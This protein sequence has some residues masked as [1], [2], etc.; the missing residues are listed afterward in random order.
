MPRT[1]LVSRHPGTAKWVESQGIA[2]DR[3]VEHL[4]MAEV[5]AGDVVIGTLPV[6]MA[7]GVCERRARYLHL[8]LEV[9][10]EARGLELTAEDMTRFGARLVEHWVKTTAS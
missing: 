5:Q 7:A 1:F 4:D 6:H 8:V 2:I 3:K 9:P 10:P